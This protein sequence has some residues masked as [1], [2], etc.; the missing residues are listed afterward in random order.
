VDGSPLAKSA[1]PQPVTHLPGLY[2]LPNDP[3]RPAPESEL[4]GHSLDPPRR[5]RGQ[6]LES[7][8]FLRSAG[9]SL[10]SHKY[11]PSMRVRHD[12]SAGEGPSS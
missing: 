5:V 10:R 4:D 7:Q 12:T 9:T 1:V 8:K 2:E 3:T 6:D 11:R